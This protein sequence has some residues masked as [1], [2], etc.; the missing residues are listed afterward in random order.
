MERRELQGPG[1]GW[2]RPWALQSERNWD[3]YSS[4]RTAM[5]TLRGPVI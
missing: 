1:C 2:E 4:D 3:V 5:A